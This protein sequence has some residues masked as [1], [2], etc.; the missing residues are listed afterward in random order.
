MDIL[1]Y[2]LTFFLVKDVLWKLEEEG[3]FIRNR[4]KI[5]FEKFPGGLLTGLRAPD[6]SISI[7]DGAAYKNGVASNLL[8]TYQGNLRASADLA[9]ALLTTTTNYFIL[10]SCLLAL[11]H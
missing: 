3:F 6:I 9:P 11:S 5:S 2:S 7:V 8:P 4:G 1:G 10:V